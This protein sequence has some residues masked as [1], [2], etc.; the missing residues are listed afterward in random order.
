MRAVSTRI[1]VS[2]NSLP[3]SLYDLTIGSVMSMLNG[4]SVRFIAKT[5]ALSA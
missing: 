5:D 2:R 4:S 3:S 1:L